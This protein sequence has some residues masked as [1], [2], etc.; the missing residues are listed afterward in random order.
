MA[1]TTEQMLKSQKA[2]DKA[3]KEGIAKKYSGYEVISVPPP[4]KPNV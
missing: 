1:Q 3:R 2:F 4:A